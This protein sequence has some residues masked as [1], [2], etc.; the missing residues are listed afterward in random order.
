MNSLTALCSHAR[1][2]MLAADCSAAPFRLRLLC[3][4]LA[5]A[6]AAGK[7]I[8]VPTGGNFD[9]KVIVMSARDLGKFDRLGVRCTP[10]PSH[11]TT[12][13]L[14]GRPLLI[15]RPPCSLRVLLCCGR[16]EF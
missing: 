2:L 12:P 7:S 14:C 1:I 15:A 11:P 8:A 16:T 9:L 13:H 10:H 3:R 6:R 4:R 5:M